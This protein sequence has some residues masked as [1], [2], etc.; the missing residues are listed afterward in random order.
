MMRELLTFNQVISQYYREDESFYYKFK[1]YTEEGWLA[2][3]CKQ[4]K[5]MGMQAWCTVIGTLV[6]HSEI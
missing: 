6:E 4:L 2:L 3:A 5:G 1:N